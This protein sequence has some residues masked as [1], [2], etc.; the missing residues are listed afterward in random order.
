MVP[1]RQCTPTFAIELQQYGRLILRHYQLLATLPR[2]KRRKMPSVGVVRQQQTQD[3][4]IL[5][6][7]RPYMREERA[8]DAVTKRLLPRQLLATTV[9]VEVER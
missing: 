7:R 3:T 2:A 4:H 5:P 1:S 6:R 9:L 8:N